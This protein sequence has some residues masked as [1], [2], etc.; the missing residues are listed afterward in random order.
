VIVRFNDF[1]EL[2]ARVETT[3]EDALDLS[4]QVTAQVADPLTRVDTGHLKGSKQINRTSE[5]AEM[6][7]TA[8]YAAYQNFGTYKMSGTHFAD[9][10]ADAGYQA[11]V[12]ALRGMF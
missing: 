10:G 2:A 3:V 7:W 6:I 5:I 12:N 9:I 8:D 1:P 11:L 4:M